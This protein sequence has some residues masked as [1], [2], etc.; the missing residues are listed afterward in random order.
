MSLLYKKCEVC[1]ADINKL[2]K[3]WNIYT[4]KAG[5]KLKCQNCETE[6]KT[7]KVIGFIGS[8]YVWVWVWVIPILLLVRF[9]DSFRLN[10][11]IEVWLYALFLYSLLE[12][13]VMVLLPLHKIDI[14]NKGK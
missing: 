10:L 13:L 4:L 8:L 7:N 2:Q 3:L 5:I 9:I 6:Y 14:K 12:L 11:G 1:G